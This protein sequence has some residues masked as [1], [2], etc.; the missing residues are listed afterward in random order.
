MKTIGITGGTGFIGR[1]LTEVLKTAGFQVVI[2][3][4][5]PEEHKKKQ[6][7]RYA[8]WCPEENKC[9]LTHFKKLNAVINL[10]GAG[11]ADKR[12]TDKRKKEIVESRVVGTRFLVDKIK[13]YAPDCKVLVSASAIGYYGEDKNGYAFSE[14]DPPAADFLAK[15]CVKWEQEA[16][17]A[18]N[19]VRT[20]LLRFGVVLGG[21]GGMYKEFAKPMNLGAKPILGPGT[22]IVSWIQVDD[23]ARLITAAVN[24]SDMRGAYNAVAPQPVSHEALVR[25][26]AKEKGGIKIPIAVPSFAVK[27]MLGELSEEV[28]KSCTVSA[29]KVID[30]GF[31]FK[32]DTIDKAV[33]ATVHAKPAKH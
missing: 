29:Q 21:D 18:A 5:N 14:D 15:T 9:D 27:L 10:A 12:W 4:R 25:A 11:I 6:H 24:N 33:Q 26:I 17:K 31:H 2:L 20:I 32:Y 7:V 13:E 19:K 23:L 16:E 3:T 1:H 8:Y 22:Q 30:T 28:L